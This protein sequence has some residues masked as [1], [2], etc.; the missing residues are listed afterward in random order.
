MKKL[1]LMMCFIVLSITAQAASWT[2]TKMEEVE[3]GAIVSETRINIYV[4]F[5]SN[6]FRIIVRGRQIPLIQVVR[7]LDT[8]DDDSFMYLC[9]SSAGRVVIITQFDRNGRL[10]NMAISSEPN[11]MLVF[12]NRL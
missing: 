3:N 6:N 1:L 9:T 10:I 12:K 2:F 5:Y 8:N 4:E 7:Q 11:K